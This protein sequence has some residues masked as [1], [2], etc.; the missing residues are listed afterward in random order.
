M[1]S[2]GDLASKKI[3]GR[4]LSRENEPVALFE[5]ESVDNPVAFI[6]FYAENCLTI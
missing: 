2:K 1:T 3:K 4:K 6:H 5:L